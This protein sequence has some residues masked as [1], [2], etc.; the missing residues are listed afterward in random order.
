MTII[1]IDDLTPEEKAK[2]L[3]QQAYQKNMTK[4]S[5]SKMI[6]NKS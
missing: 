1:N 4:R 3:K 5:R 6:E 2:M